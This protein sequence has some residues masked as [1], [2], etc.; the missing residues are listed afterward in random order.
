[1][2]ALFL[3]NVPTDGYLASNTTGMYA[4]KVSKE[5]GI[6]I[7]LRKC[8]RTYGQR[9]V[10]AEAPISVVSVVMGHLSTRTT[11]QHYARV[12]HAVA[13]KQSRRRLST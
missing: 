5:L 9:L 7:D 2:R 13:V 6:D 1:M 8:R 10:D 3:G 11:E 4:D 12:K